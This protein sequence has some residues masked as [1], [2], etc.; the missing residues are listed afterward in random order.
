MGQVLT[1]A[2]TYDLT[3][4]GILAP[5]PT[6]SHV[7][8][9][10]LASFATLAADD[11]IDFTNWNSISEVHTYVLAPGIQDRPALEAKVD[12]LHARHAAEGNG[13]ALTMGL[14][15]L[16]AIH[17][18]QGFANNNAAVRNKTHL[19]AFAS[20]AFLI[21]LIA[22]INFINLSTA[23]SARRA[24]EV[25]MRKALG[26]IRGQL[27]RQFLSESVVLAALGM[28]LAVA[29]AA[30]LL[31]VFNALLETNLVIHY[32]ENGLLVS[33]LVGITGF[34]GFVAGLYPAFVL[35]SF[36]PVEVLK[37]QARRGVAA[38]LLLQG[39][40][41]VQ[42]AI[43]ILLL[44]GSVVMTAQMT[45]F[46]EKDLGFNH[47]QIV[48][49]ELKDPN[50]RQ[51]VETFKEA[52]MQHPGVVRVAAA[53]STP[54]SNTYSLS[55]YRPE[56]A[57]DD[58][59]RGIGTVFIDQDA[60]ETWGLSLRAGRRFSRSFATDTS[61]AL[62]LNEAAVRLLGW[63]DPVGRRLRV[64]D[65]TAMQVIGVVN[66]FHFSSL[67]T[68]IRPMVFRMSPETY[69]YL[70]VR[71]D[72]RDVTATLAFLEEQWRAFA[73]AYPFDYTFVDED[74]AGNYTSTQRLSET[75][76]AF[77]LLAIFVACLGLF[78]LVSY[79]TE[80]RTNRRA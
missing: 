6:A 77:T 22:S 65:E 57:G 40:V 58:E 66:D 13:E 51:N 38:A 35:S 53:S 74:F 23:R 60:A 18:T 52:L 21:L 67:E 72:P 2:N 37:G 59:E 80:Q 24:R 17:L 3:V 26:A 8:Y 62:M 46:S 50:L 68:E 10:F 73:T 32:A 69:R 39:L 31:P 56:G 75:M 1:L 49:L 64:D 55:S 61:E 48:V 45:Y 20:I 9:D 54:G 15:P 27:I 43:A 16:T 47:E 34:V 25:G 14:Q 44:I 42:F 63:E 76:R 11:R 5:F 36:R 4:S 71:I 12:A 70:T 33:F 29:L 41:V 30:L 7:R 19:Y 28:L 79:T 78:G